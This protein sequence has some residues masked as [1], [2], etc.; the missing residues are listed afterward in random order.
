MRKKS[1]RVHDLLLIKKLTSLQLPLKTQYLKIHPVKFYEN[2]A[3][4]YGVVCS[5]SF[6]EGF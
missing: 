2:R 5:N 6:G 3:K 4:I 1:V